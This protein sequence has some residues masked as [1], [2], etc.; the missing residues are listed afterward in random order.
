LKPTC[1]VHRG[2]GRSDEYD[3]GSIQI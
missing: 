3:G 1:S 2:P